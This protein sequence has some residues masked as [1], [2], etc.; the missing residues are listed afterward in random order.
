MSIS[1]YIETIHREGH[2]NPMYRLK[3]GNRDSRI[4]LPAIYADLTV[5]RLE[6]KWRKWAGYAGRHGIIL[7]R[8]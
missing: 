7:P 3:Y 2:E 5:P 4:L 8:T 1:G 6:R